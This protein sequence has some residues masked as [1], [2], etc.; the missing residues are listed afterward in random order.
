MHLAK[1]DTLFLQGQDA[2][3]MYFVVS[4]RILYLRNSEDSPET[5]EKEFVDAGEDWIAEPILWTPSWVHV[6]NAL[7]YTDC[8]MQTVDPKAF[9]R[10]LGLVKPV[11]AIV[12]SYGSSFMSWMEEQSGFDDLNDVIQGDKVSDVIRS[13]IPASARSKTKSKQPSESCFTPKA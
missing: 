6:G 7:A 9:A 11:L 10:I 4:G 13:F 2:T 5:N 1:G 8:E 12:S 3:C